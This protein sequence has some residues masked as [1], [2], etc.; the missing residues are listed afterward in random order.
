MLQA[1]LWT[2]VVYFMTDL[3]VKDG[4]WHFW[5]YYIIV[6]L[7]AI[8]GASMV[9]FMAFVTPDRDAANGL[10]GNFLCASD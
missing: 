2:F 6:T 4:G 5:V 10:I 9:R 8:N 1:T 3:T 7:T